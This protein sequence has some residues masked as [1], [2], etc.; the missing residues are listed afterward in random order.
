MKLEPPNSVPKLASY[1]KAFRGHGEI[2]PRLSCVD[3]QTFADTLNLNQLHY[4]S[5]YYSSVAM[6]HFLIHQAN[7]FFSLLLYTIQL[8]ITGWQYY[9]SELI[10]TG[11]SAK[12]GDIAKISSFAP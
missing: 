2:R 4:Q 7:I 11:I 10:G 8:Q 1:E 12:E 6:G 3:S 5:V 9:P